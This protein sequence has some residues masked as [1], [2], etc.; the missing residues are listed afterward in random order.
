M[1]LL[2]E[3]KVR[4]ESDPPVTRQKYFTNQTFAGYGCTPLC[5]RCALRT[6]AHSLAFRVRFEASWSGELAAADSA[7][8]AADRILSGPDVKEREPSEVTEAVEQPAVM[9]GGSADQV[10]EGAGEASLQLEEDQLQP[11]DTTQS[12]SPTTG[13]TNRSAET[14]LT[15]NRVEGYIGGLRSIGWDRAAE[16]TALTMAPAPWCWWSSFSLN[17]TTLR[18]VTISQRSPHMLAQNSST[19]HF[20]TLPLMLSIPF[21]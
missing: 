14:K 10:V 8:R 19:R 2:W 12:Q 5:T 9:E 15:P 4:T 13:A 6:G 17:T 1:V 16:H 11:M 21:S 7:G 3:L 18:T 20:T